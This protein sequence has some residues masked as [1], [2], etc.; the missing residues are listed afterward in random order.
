MTTEVEE[1][2]DRLGACGCTLAVGSGWWTARSERMST[3]RFRHGQAVVM[4]S[5]VRGSALS[6]G[7]LSCPLKAPAWAGR[8]TSLRESHS[9]KSWNAGSCTWVPRL[10]EWKLM[11]QLLCRIWSG[12]VPW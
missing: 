4:W 8:L 9:C 7:K 2:E 1:A 11:L 12:F 10:W 6:S 5:V 3:G